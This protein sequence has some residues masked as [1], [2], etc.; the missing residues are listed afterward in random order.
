MAREF[1]IVLHPTDPPGWTPA[2]MARAQERLGTERVTFTEDD[3]CRPRG[4]KL[5][6]ATADNA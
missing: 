2:L 5:L 6:V 4:H 1:F 3:R